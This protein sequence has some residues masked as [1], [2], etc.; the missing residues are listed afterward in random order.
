MSFQQIKSIFV[1]QARATDLSDFSMRHAGTPLNLCV[2]LP[3]KS[4]YNI[5][6]LQYLEN[7]LPDL[8]AA[9]VLYNNPSPRPT[10]ANTG[11]D[12]QFLKH[13]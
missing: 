8:V 2:V 5:T 11:A 6:E 10:Q 1:C 7:L 12:H 9:A 13:E 3:K 4:L